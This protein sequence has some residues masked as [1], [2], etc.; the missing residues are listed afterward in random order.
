MH[1]WIS[2]DL[3]YLGKLVRRESCLHIERYLHFSEN[4]PPIFWT[5]IEVEFPLATVLLL[6]LE[7]LYE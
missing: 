4:F 6:E 3:S 5:T 1:F 7:R 2:Y